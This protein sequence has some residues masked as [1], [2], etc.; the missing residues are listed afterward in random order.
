MVNDVSWSTVILILALMLMHMLTL[1]VLMYKDGISRYYDGVST[2]AL[3]T[4]LHRRR[5]AKRYGPM[6]T[7]PT[8]FTVPPKRIAGEKQMHPGPRPML[9]GPNHFRPDFQPMYDVSSVP[10]TPCSQWQEPIHSLYG[11]ELRPL[12]G[13]VDESQAY[14]NPYLS[15]ATSGAAAPGM[16]CKNNNSFFFWRSRRSRS[17]NGLGS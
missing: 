17:M 10:V 6:H 5:A 3:Q 7:H 9:E 15:S 2:E 8:R 16:A 1:T 12:E 11:R 4:E 14:S 13:G